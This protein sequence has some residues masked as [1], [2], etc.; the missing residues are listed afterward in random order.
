VVRETVGS[1]DDPLEIE[2]LVKKG[3]QRILQLAG[4]VSFGF[5]K[6]KDLEFVDAFLNCLDTFNLV[7]PELLLGKIF[8]EIGFDVVQEE[9][10]RH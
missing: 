9:L 2:F 6:D 8:N 7:G 10:F 5:D 1:S 3:K 4:Q